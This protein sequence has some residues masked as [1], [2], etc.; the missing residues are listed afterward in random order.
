MAFNFSPTKAE[1]EA[2]FRRERRRRFL[3]YLTLACFAST[4][5]IGGIVAVLRLHGDSYDTFSQIAGDPAAPAADSAPLST[6]TG[7]GSADFAAANAVRLTTTAYALILVP[8]SRPTRIPTTYPVSVGHLAQETEIVRLVNRARAAEGLPELRINPLL[9]A[10]AQRHSDDMAQGDFLDH[11]GSDSSSSYQRI[12][13]EGYQASMT[14][15]NVLYQPAVDAARAFDNWWN[16]PS[17]RDNMIHPQFEEIGV[18][19]S[20]SASGRIYYTMTLGQA[21]I[22]AG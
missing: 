8:T 18:A 19:Y 7:S 20:V 15:E 4:L 5:G 17:H 14:G 13:D 21:S 1:R 2:R 11:T 16:S 12:T 10:A 9:T 3:T 6:D 22:R